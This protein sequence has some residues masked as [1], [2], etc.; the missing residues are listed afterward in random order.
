MFKGKIDTI[1]QDGLLTYP[2]LTLSRSLLLVTIHL[3][4][5]VS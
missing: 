3:I 2:D 5:W 1:S 4:R